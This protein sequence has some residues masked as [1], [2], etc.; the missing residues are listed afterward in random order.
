MGVV[1][2]MEFSCPIAALIRSCELFV[3][4]NVVQSLSK[5]R[6]TVMRQLLITITLVLAVT[7]S[8]LAQTTTAPPDFSGTWV[9]NAAKSTL[10]K[11]ST[12]K[13]ETIV[14][15]YKKSTIVFDYKTDGKKSKETYTPDGQKRGLPSEELRP[16]SQVAGHATASLSS[17]P[18]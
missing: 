14:V 17:G 2:S 12:I 1:G 11:D 10:A 9:L 16:L 18:L 15:A 8:S 6:A 3:A 5:G 13:S 7:F 4:R